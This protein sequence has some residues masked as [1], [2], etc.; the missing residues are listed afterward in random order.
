VHL[1]YWTGKGEADIEAQLRRLPG[2]THGSANGL[3]GNVLMLFDPRRT[4]AE[5]LIPAL[6]ELPVD[7]VP[8]KAPAPNVSEPVIL[9]I[10]GSRLENGTGPTPTEEQPDTEHPGQYVTGARR[11]L[12]RMLGWAS[13]AMAIV[14]A[15]MPGIPTAPF[16]ILAGYFFIRSS[17]EAHEWLRESRWFGQILRDWEEHHGISRTTR[18]VAVG[19]IVVS[20]IVCALL[21]LP[22]PLLLLIWAMQIIGL[23]IV[24]RLHV[25]DHPAVEPVPA[26]V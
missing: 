12:Y 20:A 13:V 25:V 2:V 3:T 7:T 23:I 22:W 4:G 19:L 26:V 9:P 21:G 15:I 18:N 16:V 11:V 24:L 5:V 1:P 8:V 10:R 14:G 6:L 17:R